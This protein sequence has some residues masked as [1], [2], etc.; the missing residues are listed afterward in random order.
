M[1]RETAREREREMVCE[2]ERNIYNEI[3][4]E[5]GGREKREEIERGTGGRERVR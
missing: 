3:Y 1:G 5:R 4:I 2:K